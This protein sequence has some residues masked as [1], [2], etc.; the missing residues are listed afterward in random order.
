MVNSNSAQL[1]PDYVTTAEAEQ[2]LT[3]IN[4]FDAKAYDA[5]VSIDSAQN[6]TQDLRNEF[7]ELNLCL[8]NIDRLMKKYDVLDKSFYG[9]YKISRK[10]SDLGTRHENEIPLQG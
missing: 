10:I 3:A 4:N 7:K 8:K 6:A 9:N 2:W 5:G 1:N